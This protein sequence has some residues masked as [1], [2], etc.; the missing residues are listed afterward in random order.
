MSTPTTGTSVSQTTLTGNAAVNSLLDGWHWSSSTISYSFLVPGVSYYDT[1]YPALSFWTQI[2]AFTAIQQSATLQALAAWSNVANVH[3][4]YSA[5]NSTTSGTIRLGFSSSYSWGSSVGATYYPNS[6]PAGGDL[7]L[8][9]VASDFVNSYSAGSFT[10]SSFLSG[11]Y[12]YFSLLHELGHA[13]GFKHPFDNSTDGGGQSIDGTSYS[14]WDSRVYTIMSYTP[15]SNHSDAIGFSFNPT[16]PMLLD[17]EAIQAIYGAN[18]AYNSGNT[19]YAYNDNPGQYYFQTIWDGGG[20]NTIA[21]SGTHTV[22]VD[23]REGY[24]SQI[25]NL[26]YAY[27]STNP[28][29]YTVNNVW[30]AYGA[31]IQVADL[32]GCNAGFAVT[33]NNYGDKIICGTGTGTINGGTGGDTIIIGSGTETITC[34]SGVDTIV[35]DHARLSYSISYTGGIFHLSGT[36]GAEVISGAENFAFTDGT[37]ATALL[38]VNTNNITLTAP[39]GSV[40]TTSANDLVTGLSG[41]NSVV[42]DGLQSQYVISGSAGQFQ[43]QDTVSNRDGTDTVRNIER[44]QFSDKS[45]ALDINPSFTFDVSGNAGEVAKILGVVF[46][47]TTIQLHPDYVGIGLRMLDAGTSNESLMQLALGVKIGAGF[48]T[49]QEIQL[50]YTNLLGHAASSADVSFWSGLVTSGQFTQV[51][52]AEMAADTAV[53]AV[54]INFVGLAQTGIQYT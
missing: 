54:N 51:T 17:V 8:D 38:Q 10:N 26:V 12:A 31:K 4:T 29:A 36:D 7:W 30:I 9:P 5:D 43:I 45:V 34:G 23:L 53:N 11:S 25:G 28:T 18:Y 33:A 39:N 13:L 2:E 41:I 42:Y 21:Y 6:A 50:I 1:N 27:T 19:V 35:F 40:H 46:G 20:T 49:A 52:L 22:T 3:F 24:G 44:L 48:T 15:L 32:S 47:S 37:V 14:A 16:T